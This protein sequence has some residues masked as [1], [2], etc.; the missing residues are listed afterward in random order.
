M[1][2]VNNR[3]VQGEERGPG[4]LRK[5]IV[6]KESGAVLS[7]G[8]EVTLKPGA[9]IKLHIHDV[10]EIIFVHSG[11]LEA[12]LGDEKRTIGPD[13]TIVAPAGVFHGVLNTGDTDARIITFFPSPEPQSTYKE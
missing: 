7:S 12:T 9:E 13:N 10:E 8:G 2:I 6:T 5:M 4:M 3:E 11:Q 1:T